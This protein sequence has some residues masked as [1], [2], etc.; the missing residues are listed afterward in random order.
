MSFNKTAFGR[1]SGNMKCAPNV[2]SLSIGPLCRPFSSVSGAIRAVNRSRSGNITADFVRGN[3]ICADER[4]SGISYG[5]DRLQMTAYISKGEGAEEERRP[6]TATI[7]T[8][9]TRKRDCN[10]TRP[11]ASGD[12]DKSWFDRREH[13]AA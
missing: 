8:S 12:A 4:Q 9:S 6:A 11:G 2:T 5:A 10:A 3:S 1:E 7:Q 13:Y